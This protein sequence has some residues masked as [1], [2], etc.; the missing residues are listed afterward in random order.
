[1][2]FTIMF[3]PGL[4]VQL[5][6]CLGADKCMTADDEIQGS[7]VRSQPSHKRK[8]VHKVLVNCLVKLSQDKSVVR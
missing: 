2:C 6:M 5:V 1:M 8:Y 3:K 7:Q 4:V